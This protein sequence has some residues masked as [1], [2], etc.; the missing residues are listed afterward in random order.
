MDTLVLSTLFLNTLGIVAIAV[1]A[2]VAY[3]LPQRRH[4]HQG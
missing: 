4:T 2:V 3:C 1:G